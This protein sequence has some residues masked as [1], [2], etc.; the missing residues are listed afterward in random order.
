MEEAKYGEHNNP[1]YYNNKQLT[2]TGK[3]RQVLMGR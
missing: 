3:L 1:T 2:D